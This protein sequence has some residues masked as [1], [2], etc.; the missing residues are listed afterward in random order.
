[1][2]TYEP[3]FVESLLELLPRSPFADILAELEQAELPGLAWLNWLL[4]IPE[5]L[6][7]VAV[8]LLAIALFYG[9]SILMRWIKMI[10]D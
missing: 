3:G 9:Y 1:M 5:F 8:W 7:V 4:P 2:E 10:G 6:T